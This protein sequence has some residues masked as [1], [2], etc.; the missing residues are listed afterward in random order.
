MIF[1]LRLQPSTPFFPICFITLNIVEVV[2]QEPNSTPVEIRRIEYAPTMG[3]HQ[4]SFE[5]STLFSPRSFYE[6]FYVL[7]TLEC[8]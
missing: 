7:H 3:D 6:V 5:F 4:S 8:K 2:D 1:E